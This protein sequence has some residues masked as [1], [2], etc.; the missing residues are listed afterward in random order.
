MIVKLTENQLSEVRYINASP[1]GENY[2]NSSKPHRKEPMEVYNQQSIKNTDKIRVFHGCSIDTALEIC[3][4][5]TSGK[6]FHPRQYSY[7]SGMNPL[8]IF[9]TVDFEKAKDFGYSNNAVCILEF[10]VKA[11]DLESPVWNN[12]D[13]Y[14]VQGSNPQPFRNAEE[15]RSQKLNQRN[16]AKNVKDETYFDYDKKRELTIDR[17]YIRNSDKP[18]MAQYVFD[19]M[20]HQSLFMGDLNPNMIKYVWVKENGEQQ[21]QKYTEKDFLKKYNK[22]TTVSKGDVQQKRLQRSQNKLFSPNDNVSSWNDVVNRIIERD[23]G[24]PWEL[25]KDEIINFFNEMEIMTKPSEFAIDYLKRNLW[26]KQIIQLYGRDFF[27]KYFNRLE[28]EF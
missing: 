25:S 5:G 13:S 6:V 2:Y 20:E 23:K 16:N 27:N 19:N 14:F 21:Y 7:E 18:E 15:R 1:R 28:Q 11:S 26:P 12:S 24:T 4:K 8:G 22:A 10:T 3:T 9:V 17:S